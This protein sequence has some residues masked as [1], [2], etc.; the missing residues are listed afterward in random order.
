MAKDEVKLKDLKAKL[1]EKLPAN[2][3][4]LAIDFLGMKIAHGE[5]YVTLIQSKYAEALVKNMGLVNCN[6]SLIPCDTSIDLST[7][8]EEA[9]DKDFPY[10]SIVGSLLYIATHT[11]PDI[12]VATSILARYVD[13]PSKKHQ[14]AA[15][16]VVKYLKETPELGLK[17][18]AGDGNQLVA[19]VDANWAGEPGAGRRSRTG[20]V[21]FYGKAAVYYTTAL[22]KGVTLSSTEAEYIALSEAA[23]QITWLRRVLNELGH[24]AEHN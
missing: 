20:I 7:A 19:Y 16:K 6:G 5:G 8:S 9:A 18:A 23:K 14:K 11:R 1:A 21:L 22:Q 2:D 3:M 4:R 17:L 12:A 13:S 10:R 24:Q 15:T